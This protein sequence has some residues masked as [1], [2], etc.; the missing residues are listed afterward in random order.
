MLTNKTQQRS[1]WNAVYLIENGKMMVKNLK[2]TASFSKQSAAA[3]VSNW[4]SGLG[5]SWR[6]GGLRRS[7][8]LNLSNDAFVLGWLPCS[9]TLNKDLATMNKITE[10]S[11]RPAEACTKPITYL[12][13]NTIFL[14]VKQ[15]YSYL[16]SALPTQVVVIITGKDFMSVQYLFAFSNSTISYY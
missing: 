16:V 14:S 5:K 9:G 12:L 2:I 7:P 10:N 11:S 4:E 15:G 13:G 3:E 8:F 1:V 6:W